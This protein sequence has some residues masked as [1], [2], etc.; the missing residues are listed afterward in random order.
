MKKLILL[1]LIPSAIFAQVGIN[2][3]APT[4]TLDVTAKA[5]TGTTTDVDGMLIPKIN[6]QRA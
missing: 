2:T 5:S 1:T 3:S 4:S 6:L